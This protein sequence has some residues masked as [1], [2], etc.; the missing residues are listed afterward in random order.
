MDT[1]LN[2]IK[3]KNPVPKM[4]RGCVRG[5]TQINN[6]LDKQKSTLPNWK[7]YFSCHP[8]DYISYGYGKNFDIL[9]L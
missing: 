3:N 6:L 8:K 5:A 4:G 7:K 9:F 2:K 1:P